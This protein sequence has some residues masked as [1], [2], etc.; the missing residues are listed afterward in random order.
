MLMIDSAVWAIAEEIGGGV[1]EVLNML[2]LT[3]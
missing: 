2:I 1:L 3:A